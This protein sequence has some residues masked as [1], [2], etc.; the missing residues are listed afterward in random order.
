MTARPSRP[1]RTLLLVTAGAALLALVGCSS[2]AEEDSTPDRRSFALP[3]TTLTVDSDG[4]ALELVP[5]DHEE[6]R[7]TRWF[8]GRKLIGS[9]PTFSWRMQNDQLT[10]RHDCSG[11]IAVCDLKHRI[12]VPRDTS[13]TVRNGDG[14]V[15]ASGFRS[16]LDIT[17]RSG[18]VRV[19]DTSGALTLRSSDGSISAEGVR[20]RRVTARTDDGSLRLS[21]AA[22]PGRVAARSSDGSVTIALPRGEHEA[23]RYR[24]EARSGDGS[25]TVSVPRDERSRHSVSARSGNGSVTVRHAN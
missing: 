7:V 15:R 21:L 14:S 10:L 17:T 4:S 23:T 8:Q 6:V 12:E 25:V 22:V 3:G 24:V 1:R 18:S 19:H 20:S 11:F 9:S 2:D 5:A 13:V 16:P